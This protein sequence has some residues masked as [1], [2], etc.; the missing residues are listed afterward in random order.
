MRRTILTALSLL[1]TLGLVLAQAPAASADGTLTW[2]P[3]NTTTTGDQD[4]S[5]VASSRGGHTAIVWE[6]DRDATNPDD[7]IHSE[8]YVRLYKDGTSL[9]EKKV[10]PGGTGNWR[11]VQ[12]DVAVWPDGRVAVVWADD[13]DGN[14]YYQ[15]KVKTYNAAGTETGSAT[16]NA[17]AAGQQVNPEIAVDPDG[18]GFAVVF[19]D[20][21]TDAEPTVRLSGFNSI[22]SKAYE[23]RVH[24]AGGTNRH[25]D[26]AMGAAGNAIVVWDEDGDANGY[27]NIGLASFTPS[28]G[29]KLAKRVANQ[30]TGGQQTNVTVAANFNGDFVAAWVTDH[31]GSPQTAVRSF[32]ATGSA[33]AEAF[34]PG[35]DPQAGLS[36]Q[37]HA[38]VYWTEG[39]D[40]Y[41]QGINPDGTTADRQPRIRANTVT[42]G[43]QTQPALAVD[44]FGRITMTYTDDADGDGFDDILIGTGLTNS[45]W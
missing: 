11:H 30:A 17:T 41:V 39:E 13:P 38:V 12:P 9:F 29:A 33:P 8:V 15:I 40:V 5:S 2:A 18:N 28:G 27:Y 22:T 10:T 19:E 14:G 25:P 43:R 16:A 6:D 42:A 23:V 45:T 26:V 44:P 24:A 7:S 37:R 36:D 3:A 31:L 1:S 35:S 34:V 32:T 4:N 20:E 21:Q